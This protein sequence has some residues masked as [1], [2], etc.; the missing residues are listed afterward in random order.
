MMTR[1]N[2]FF[3][4]TVAVGLLLTAVHVSTAQVGHGLISGRVVD[5]RT[6][7][8]LPMAS[9]VVHSNELGAATDLDGYYRVE[10]VPE[11]SHTVAVS[12]IG[13]A[14]Y[15]ITGVKVAPDRVTVIDAALTPQAIQVQGVS[16]TA[17]RARTTVAGLLGSQRAAATVSSGISSD[18]IS[19]TGDS[20]ASDALKRVTGLTV[21]DDR[22]VFVRGLNERYSN[23]LLNKSSL[24]SPEPDKRV[25]PFDIFPSGLL[26]DIVVMKGFTPD[27]PGDFAGGSIQL[28]TKDFPEQMVFKVNASTGLNTQTTFRNFYT[29]Q[30]G[31][32][33]FLGFD[34]GTR[35]LPSLV[36]EAIDA[37][38]PFTDE[39]ARAFANIW[40]RQRMTAPLDQSYSASFGNDYS[41]GGRRFGLLGALSYRNGFSTKTEERKLFISGAG[42][43][44]EIR[45]HYQDYTV[46]E[47]G[48]LAGA[49]LNMSY[50]P[51]QRDKLSL[52]TTYTRTSEDEVTSWF[53]QN[54]DYDA[55]WDFYQLKWV[56]RSLLSTEL[57]GDHQVR[58]LN[59]R[60]GWNAGY[61]TAS[62][63]EPDTRR[64]L[65][66]TIYAHDPERDTLEFDK[67]M[68]I[69]SGSRFYSHLS[70]RSLNAGLDWETPFKQW[71]SLPSKLSVGGSYVYKDRGIDSRRF[72]F[73][74]ISG[75]IAGV[76]RTLAPEDIFAP[77]N[78]GPFFRLRDDT[79]RNDNYS[80][81]QLV[82]AAYAMLD[83]PLMPDLRFA[84][85]VRAENSRQRVRTYNLFA[86]GDEV[87]GV[88]DNFDI[89][90]SA[91]LTYKLT[92]DMNLRAAFAQTV[93]RPSFREL[94]EQEFTNIDGE[95]VIGN[96]ELRRTLIQNYDVRWEWYFGPAEHLAV[97]GFYKHFDLP[98]EQRFR[99]ST[100][101]LQTYE[102]AVTAYS[103]RCEVEARTGLGRLA[104]GLD[105]FTVTGNVAIIKSWVRLPDDGGPETRTERPL[106]GQSPYVVNGMLSYD[107]PRVGMDA[108]LSYNV[109]GPRIATAGIQ[110]IP[111]IIEQPFH[112]LDFVLSKSLLGVLE[113][114]LSAKNLLDP[115][116][117]Y[118]QGE[119]VQRHYRKGRS[120]SLGLSYAL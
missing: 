40:S 99:N 66:S 105:P 103:Y 75:W 69:G 108:S 107:V 44:L 1:T 49:M 46:S 67:D 104:A 11:G 79:R 17:E 51:S 87:I 84:G 113:A 116:V 114:K 110:G 80:G 100:E 25:V 43:S 89:M 94:S 91:N 73:D 10:R 85:G 57:T 68:E 30:G 72:Q 9:V 28:T 18:E 41:L 81:T 117:E 13:Y 45:K 15:N 70:D 102:N 3:R 118:T 64:V 112:R 7:E 37:G 19:R 31:A 6:R 74:G 92:P 120:F 4:S 52:R 83:M 60:I 35:R 63:D 119:K 5:S 88:V 29:Y 58:L 14:D 20:R 71:S 54:R 97:A 24:P 101:L 16:V 48:I 90:P 42:D 32:L 26:S 78:I 33:D 86:P 23:V 21:V 8:P 27:M 50:K 93:S 106:Q 109:F 62:R 47:F 61:S 65:Y 82:G 36:R 39:H 76:D 115:E 38:N 53:M 96:P 12:M 34:D 111:D 77:Q 56:E 95:P 22:Y 59:S 55:D 98:V 2:S